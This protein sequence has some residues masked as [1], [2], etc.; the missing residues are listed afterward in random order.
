MLNKQKMISK[1]YRGWLITLEDL[2]KINTGEYCN[3]VVNIKIDDL[4][5][6]QIIL[7][8][9]EVNK[10]S[11]H[12]LTETEQLV[13]YSERKTY[14]LTPVIYN[15]NTNYVP[16]IDHELKPIFL[17][18]KGVINVGKIYATFVYKYSVINI[19]ETNLFTVFNGTF[20]VA[21]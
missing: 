8:N 13:Y 3:K 10:K 9:Y 20:P 18:E 5:F 19:Q 11:I 16:K 17:K 1:K 15:N 21:N 6:Q 4:N 2:K 12:I 14:M 7:S